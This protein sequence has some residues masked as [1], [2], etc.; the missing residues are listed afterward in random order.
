MDSRE[1]LRALP[2]VAVLFLWQFPHFMAIAWMYRDDYA[3]AGYLIFPTKNAG[4]FLAWWAGPGSA[5]LN[6]ISKHSRVARKV[7]SRHGSRIVGHS[8]PT[9]LQLC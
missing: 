2:G 9:L 4:R 5:L 7:R 6:L 3:R 1:G 8:K